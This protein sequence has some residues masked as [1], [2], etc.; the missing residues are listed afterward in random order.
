MK[1]KTGIKYD[2][3]GIFYEGL[4]CVKLNGKYGFVNTQDQIVV[5]IIYD[6]VGYFNEGLAGVKFKGIF[7]VISK[8]RYIN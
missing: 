8:T 2:W 5:P 4:A 7:G 6:Y 3:V 1:S